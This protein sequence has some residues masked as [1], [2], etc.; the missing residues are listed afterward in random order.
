MDRKPSHSK[1]RIYITYLLRTVILWF[2]E[3]LGFILIASLSVGLTVNSWQTAVLVVTI[4]GILNLFFWPILSRLFLPFLVYTVG[5][6]A[7]LLNGLMIWFVSNFVTGITIE[8]W[9]LILTPIGM[10]F[11]TTILS[12]II[13]IDDDASYYR[14]VFQRN[15]RGMNDHQSLEPGV[16]FLEIDGLAHKV[17]KEALDNGFMPTLSN[18]LDNGSHKLTVW[19]TDL[20]SQT[21]ASQAGILHGNNENIPAFRWVEKSNENRIMVSTGLSDAPLI[22]ERI[23]DGRGLLSI[24]GASRSNLFSGDAKDIIFTYSHLKNLRKF[25][26]GAWYYLY[27]SP[28]SFGRIIVLYIGDV[29]RDF[30]SQLKHSIK[31]INPRIY[32]GFSYPFIR[33]G[34]NV[35]LREVTTY[36]LIGDVITGKIDVAYVTYLGYDEIA[37][38]SGVRDEDSF[39]ALKGLDKQF[40]RLET[41]VGYSHRPYKF[42]IQSDHGQ[43][44][45]STFKQRYGI[46][47]E[48]LVRGLIPSHIKI[49]SEL[50]SNEDHFSQAITTPIDS[51]K[52]YFRN[53]KDRTVEKS[54]EFF[55]DT[56]KNFEKRGIAK[57][58]YSKGILD[59]IQSYTVDKNPKI[60][61]SSEAEVI[62]LAS[63]NLGLIYFTLWEN[64]LSFEEIK[65]IFPDIIPGIVKH[66]GIG[67]IM[68]HSD[69]YGPIVIGSNGIYYLKT[70]RIEGENPLSNFGPNAAQHLK[71]TDQ[72]KYVPDI[73]VNSIYDPIKDEVAAFEE[74]VGSHGGLGGDQSYPFVMYPS[75]WKLEAEDIIGAEKLHEVLKARL[76]QDNK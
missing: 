65:D 15:I 5:I 30:V 17:L 19:E 40:S 18:W 44:N 42:V 26:S 70:D 52:M 41:A 22:E 60:K 39:N 36:T 61:S 33:A 51:S 24:K 37:H 54:R 72:F 66:P 11:I 21:G 62:V 45:G 23:S 58:P 12:T 50:S 35:F 47:L 43:T 46:S 56:I 34:A 1:K 28:S 6:G 9:A 20:S 8:G 67:F 14:L 27:S 38:H 13:T 59:Y 16:I 73:V 4:I 31:N 10:A 7:L 74:L 64:R 71:R 48:D 2:G 3:V 76:N 25:Y 53:K 57:K 75:E 55:S 32:R 49:Y 29:L 69:E 63:G 68:V